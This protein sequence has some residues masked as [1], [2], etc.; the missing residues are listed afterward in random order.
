MAA[1][2]GVNHSPGTLPSNTIC[3]ADKKYG[4]YVRG[5]YKDYGISSAPSLSPKRKRQVA[6]DSRK[7][8]AP[9]WNWLRLAKL[10]SGFCSLRARSGSR[11]RWKS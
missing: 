10:M 7:P 6:P 9:Y 5:G 4:E 1:E 2:A 3:N 8:F 11:E